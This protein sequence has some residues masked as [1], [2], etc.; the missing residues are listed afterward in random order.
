MLLLPN[1]LIRKMRHHMYRA[2]RREI[3][4]MIMGED[5]GNQTF[6]VVD[7]S[8]DT[9]SGTRSNF[10]RDADLHDQALAEFF[11]RTGADYRRFNYLGE[12]HTHPSFDVLPSLQD[13]HAMQDLVDGSGKVSFAVLLIARL[14]WYWRFDGSA[15]LFVKGHVPSRVELV[16]EN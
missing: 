9:V 14:K 3:G 2:G 7:F 11:E 5:V 4:G 12:W 10:V 15:H 16:Q 1:D 8:I 13:L 6:R